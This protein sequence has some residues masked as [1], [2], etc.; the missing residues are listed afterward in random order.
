MAAFR[1]NDVYGRAGRFRPANSHRNG[2]G[3]RK[4][5]ESVDNTAESF[6][7]FVDCQ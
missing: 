6:H 1:D 2:I 5:E 7:N 4:L 3:A